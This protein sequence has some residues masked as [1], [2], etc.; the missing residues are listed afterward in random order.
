MGLDLKCPK[1]LLHIKKD[2][3]PVLTVVKSYLNL[4]VTMDGFGGIGIVQPLL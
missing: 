1:I 3:L 2:G 4:M